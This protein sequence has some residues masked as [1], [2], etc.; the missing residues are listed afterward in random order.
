MSTY[1]RQQTR[2]SEVKAVTAQRYD[3]IFALKRTP[4]PLIN[5]LVSRL[6]ALELDVVRLS[7][8][9]GKSTDTTTFLCVTV[10]GSVLE[11]L[12]EQFQLQKT[13]NSAAEGKW[14]ETDYRVRTFT[15]ADRASFTNT[16]VVDFSPTERAFLLQSCLETRLV[17]EDAWPAALAA[18]GCSGA[19]DHP[20]A[21]WLVGPNSNSSWDGQLPLIGAL[22]E[23][24]YLEATWPAHTTGR[25]ESLG[26]PMVAPGKRAIAWG[27]YLMGLVTRSQSLL[28]VNSIRVYWGD[29]VAYYF[30]WQLF[31]IRMLLPLGL[32]GL[33]IHLRR[34]ADVT[35]D[36]DP[37][38][39]LFS[40]VAVMWAIAFVQGWR[41]K[42]AE[43]AFAWGSAEM[44]ATTERL[45]PSFRGREVLDPISGRL[46]QK[47]AR[48]RRALRYTVSGT[49]SVLCLLV[50]VAVMFA[51]LNLQG[52]ITVN[53]RDWFGVPVYIP[54]I[55][56]FAAPG[57]LFDPNGKLGRA[58]V[59]LHAVT[60]SLLNKAY[61]SVARALTRLENHRT[62]RPFEASLL[63]K[64]FAFE[65]LDCYL[66]LFYIAFELQDVPRLR[67]EL[68]ALYTTDT[69]RR[70]LCETLLPLLLHWRAARASHAFAADEAAAAEGG[71]STAPAAPAAGGSVK[72][73]G[74]VKSPTSGAIGVAHSGLATSGVNM[75][76][77]GLATDHPVLTRRASTQNDESLSPTATR[78]ARLLLDVG[79]GEGAAKSSSLIVATKL[80]ARQLAISAELELEVYQDFDDYLEMVIQFGYVTLFASAFPLAAIVSFLCNVL[81]LLS[82]AF[83]L[84]SLH[85]RPRPH[86]VASIG[87][88]GVCL[89]VLC[90][91]SIYTN[92]FICA[93]S[94]DQLAAVLPSLFTVPQSKQVP[95]RGWLGGGRP[96]RPT[97]G[98][99][100]MKAGKGRYV[101]LLCV[102][103]EHA[104]FLLLLAGE[105]M[106]ARPPAW[107][108]LVLKR[109]EFEQREARHKDSINVAEGTK[110]LKDATFVKEK[111]AIEHERKE[112]EARARDKAAKERES[113]ERSRQREAEAE[114]R[115]RLLRQSILS[116][117]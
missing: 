15:R 95:H 6:A 51:S 16:G 12:A 35:V 61:R 10:T 32:L 114:V 42:Q 23:L 78:H 25:Y 72:T 48:W 63:L 70:V 54:L 27:A 59:L 28:D 115:A 99:H 29:Q 24:G 3:V 13:L 1:S 21:A 68:I 102:A 53:D 92:L 64:R 39:P 109:R 105:W 26:V 40:L 9:A 57:A 47:E 84:V 19:A 104:M 86:R 106:L 76:H 31:Y 7:G 69:A 89:F 77:S 97:S 45:R 4:E 113:K 90:V 112:T 79:H 110:K 103:A 93:I 49:I 83:K 108:Q 43:L 58:P 65:S 87:G 60:I 88:W 46:I 14:S 56:K 81:E 71:G 111:D 100:E 75:A 52:Y 82:D 22:T 34:P 5:Y 38:L 85:R 66:A 11:P 96:N 18:A 20:K 116:G 107:V 91:A 98:E 30:A 74:S 117:D 73:G 41:G 67:L 80:A 101:V 62:E 8:G 94:S 33:V 50:P 36:D 37:F 2:A 17:T 44:G 55:A